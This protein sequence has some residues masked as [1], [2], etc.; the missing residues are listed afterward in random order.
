MLG[1]VIIG[2]IIVISSSSIIILVTNFVEVVYAGTASL[3]VLRR[4]ISGSGYLKIV[5]NLIQNLDE[6]S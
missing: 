5:F 2:L 1:F 4:L 3:L 6:V